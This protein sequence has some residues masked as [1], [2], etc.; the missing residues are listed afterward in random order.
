M[1]SRADLPDSCAIVFLV[2][3]ERL[4][5]KALL[6]LYATSERWIFAGL[7][8]VAGKVLV[9][10]AYQNADYLWR[11]DLGSVQRKF[12]NKME[13]KVILLLDLDFHGSKSDY[14]DHIYDLLRWP[15][16]MD[17]SKLHGR[18]H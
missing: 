9:D 3:L 15:R 17:L 16:K 2:Y 14:A 13:K 7:C 8:L 1:F 4:Y 12:S 10:P 5:V 11:L 6:D 18:S